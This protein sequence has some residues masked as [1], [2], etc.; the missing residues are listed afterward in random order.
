M[1]LDS[2]GSIGNPNWQKIIDAS[3]NLVDAY[4]VSETGTHFGL[5]SYSTNVSLDISFTKFTGANRNAVNLKRAI[6]MLPL[7]GGVTYIDKALRLANE[8]LFDESK[9]MRKQYKKVRI[10]KPIL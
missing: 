5:I 10:S 6:D 7:Q 2:S 1:L 4:D 3:K 9:G 8:E